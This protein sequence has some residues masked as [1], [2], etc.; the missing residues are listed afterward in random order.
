MYNILYFS[1]SGSPILL[2]LDIQTDKIFEELQFQNL[3]FFPL[4]DCLTLHHH[5]LHIS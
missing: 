2:F 3:F 5:P 4:S 1:L